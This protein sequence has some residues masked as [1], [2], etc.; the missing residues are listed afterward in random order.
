M[1]EQFAIQNLLRA[2]LAEIQASNPRY[3]LRAYSKKVG[4]HVGALTC[5]INGKR[6]VSRTLAERI[7]QRLMLDPQE[8]SELLSLF[9]ERRRYRKQDESDDGSSAE[10][11]ARYLRFS[12]SQ[13]RV[14]AEWEHLAVMSLLNCADFQSDVEWIAARLGITEPRARQVVD[15]LIDLE[16][17]NLNSDGKLSR[18]KKNYRTSD[19]VADISI[20]RHHEQSFEL[21]KESLHRDSVSCRD[22][23]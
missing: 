12:A 13:Y 3:S 5:I 4:V 16:L 9:P 20:K 10:N 11:E 23:T 15:R 19:D 21:A 8:R 22:F 1:K 18:S 7:A 14:T 17:L 6:N 2:R